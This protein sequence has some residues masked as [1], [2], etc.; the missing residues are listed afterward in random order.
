MP[1]RRPEELQEEIGHARESFAMT[2][3]ELVNERFKA[4]Q[5]LQ[6]HPVGYTLTVSGV[7]IALGLLFGT[8]L[9]RILGRRRRRQPRFLVRI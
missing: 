9:G 4:R 3:D 1:E 2:V 5:Q 7:S 6:R 8:V